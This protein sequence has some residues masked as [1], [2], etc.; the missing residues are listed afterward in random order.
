[1]S[2][3]FL[4]AVTKAET[5]LPTLSLQGGVFADFFAACQVEKSNQK[6][7]TQ[8]VEKPAIISENLRKC[9]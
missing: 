8:I 4:K 6:T 5:F 2:L 3:S 7:K 1:M 9:K